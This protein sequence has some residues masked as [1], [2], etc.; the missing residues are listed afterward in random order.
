MKKRTRRTSH[1]EAWVFAIVLLGIVAAL[2]F[3]VNQKDSTKPYNIN[4]ADLEYYYSEL[5]ILKE[6]SV[7]IN[8]AYKPIEEAFQRIK[9][10]EDLERNLNIIFVSLDAEVFPYFVAKTNMVAN[11]KPAYMLLYSKALNLEAQIFLEIKRTR[12]AKE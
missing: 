2:I 8:Q 12:M 3:W 1:S 10:G 4:Q 11:T 5:Q 6:N 9:D 7:E